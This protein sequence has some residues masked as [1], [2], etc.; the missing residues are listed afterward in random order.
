MAARSEKLREC[1]YCYLSISFRHGE[2][3]MQIKQTMQFPLLCITLSYVGM[4]QA[5]R[6]I[7]RR[8]IQP[9][10]FVTI[11]ALAVDRRAG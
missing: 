8:S 2:S 6:T 10:A 9:T 11:I 5:R 1:P 7:L 3:L 4:A